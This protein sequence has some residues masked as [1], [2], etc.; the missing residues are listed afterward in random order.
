M[1]TDIK[2]LATDALA[3]MITAQ[4][5]CAV[6]VVANGKTVSGIKDSKVSEPS[7]TNNGETGLTTSR[8]FV[9]ADAIGEIEKGQT[10]IVGGVAVFALRCKTDPAGAIT[11]IDYSEQR[12][13]TFSTDPQ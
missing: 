13:V 11:T 3:A 12:P 7:L 6:T 8:I 4:P 1:T 9:N 10:I 2:T 5:N